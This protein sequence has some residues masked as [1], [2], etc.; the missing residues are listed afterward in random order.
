[1][2]EL[3]FLPAALKEWHKLDKAV[4]MQFL[5]KLD[6]LL[7]NP[8]IPS[9]KLRDHPDCY[10]VKAKRAG[11]R[12]VYHVSDQRVTITVLRAARRDKEEAYEGLIERLRLLDLS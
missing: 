10:R 6:K 8:R 1:L 7:A 12:L 5:K 2:F 9:M 3:A 11:Y 4:Q